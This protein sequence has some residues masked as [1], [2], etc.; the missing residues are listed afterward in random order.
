MLIV[1]V[2]AGLLSACGS[3]EVSPTTAISGS[4]APAGVEPAAAPKFPVTISTTQGPITIKEQPRRVVALGYGDAD[5]AIALGTE[6]VGVGA[7]SMFGD[8]GVGPW[9]EDRLKNRPA[10]IPEL[11]SAEVSQENQR[12]EQIEALEPDLILQTDLTVEQDVYDRLSQ[13]APVV[14]GP[15]MVGEFDELKFD[16]QTMH[17]AEALGIPGEGRKLLDRLQTR[18]EGVSQ[19]NP[20]FTGKT[21]ASLTLQDSGWW[22]AL[23]SSN[24][25][26]FFESLGFE[27]N[28]EIEDM[29]FDAD[30]AGLTEF[31]SGAVPVPEDG[32]SRVNS[33]L[34]VLVADGEYDADDIT[35]D[36]E[37][38]ELPAT[39]AGHSLVLDG[40][41]GTSFAVALA[42]PTVLSSFWMLDNFVPELT[43]HV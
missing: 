9:A 42:R 11:E 7:W 37:F 22:A 34:L 13:I 28:P 32:F 40:Q 31:G 2:V 1:L 17:I 33:D 29:A 10:V 43:K 26:Q 18:T 6:P 41:Q 20:Q 39:R 25:F 15:L 36:P 4:A 30:Q 27:Q 14:T 35:A 12:F 8:S 38:S 23:D 16:H 3:D 5:T 21:V 19:A 24:P